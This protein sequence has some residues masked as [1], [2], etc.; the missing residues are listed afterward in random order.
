MAHT[1]IVYLTNK[2]LILY[3]RDK[4]S[5]REELRLDDPQTAQPALAEYFNRHGK[6]P[7]TV[8]LDIMEET[9]KLDSVPHLNSRDRRAL[10]QRKKNQLFP[11]KHFTYCA[12]R[13]RDKEGRRDDRVLLAAITEAQ[14]IEVWLD[15]LYE[16]QI[17]VAAIV[18]L[19]IQSEKLVKALA[20]RRHK[21]LISLTGDNNGLILRQSYF[22][23][24]SLALS[25][26]RMI[27]PCSSSELITE[28]KEEIDRTRRFIARQYNLRIY[29]AVA[30]HFFFSDAKT[31]QLFTTV[32]FADVFIQANFY[33]V[34]EFAA[35]VGV[36]FPE[37]SGIAQLVAY[38][39]SGSG[40]YQ[41]SKSRYYYD[42]YRAKNGLYLLSAL[43]LLA[44]AGYM[45]LGVIDNV[46]AH[47]EIERLNNN[48][49]E[50]AVRLTKIKAAPSIN[51]F[52]SFEMQVLL[53]AREQLQQ[54]II[55]PETMLEPVSQV[56]KDFPGIMLTKIEWGEQT[57]FPSTGISS[58]SGLDVNLT[59]Q[60]PV[61][62]LLQAKIE[63]FD[64]D[65]RRALALIERLSERLRATGTL[66]N[67]KTLKQPVD[68]AAEKELIGTAGEKALNSEFILEMQWRPL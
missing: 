15:L 27:N 12:L 60:S 33:K 32:D 26:F 39:L 25:R 8:L 22:N 2:G 35:A 46:K 66:G 59:A 6:K 41:E 31:Q 3:R 68:I 51:G 52:D 17:P 56:L 58:Y 53:R 61:R 23:D 49:E 21:L 18:S 10:L 14:V 19:A 63:P 13:G 44:G 38:Q 37:N 42:H 5:L 50:I 29:E 28:I 57:G 45:A 55:M 4:K 36:S 65:Y 9:H 30:S 48:R 1:A 43:I 54:T 64:G 34:E 67:V 62:I 40:H 7:V 47:D 24:N 16:L 20:G 11:G